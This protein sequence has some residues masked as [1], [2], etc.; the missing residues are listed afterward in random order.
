MRKIISTDCI[1]CNSRTNQKVLFCKPVT[2]IDEDSDNDGEFA[3]K[4]LNE[5]M[6]IQCAGCNTITFLER[7]TFIE[8]NEPG[9]DPMTVDMNYP[10]DY[11]GYNFLQ[12]DDLEYLPRILRNLYYEV[13]AAF[14]NDSEVLS[15]M[16]LR[17]LVEAI[18][19]QQNADGRNLQNK[20]IALKQKGLL[21]EH[22]LPILDKL[23]LI[24]NVAA[25]QI[26]GL[27]LRQLS[28][29]LDIVNHVLKSIYILP[30]INKQIRIK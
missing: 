30:Q 24:G 10:E 9:T 2:I 28:Y 3:T 20:I 25:H 19:M 26:K 23:R 17:T 14:K 7:I 16:G 21:S 27:P 12:E 11:P 22:E 8:P 13:I 5:Y 1:P 6:V 4:T 15:G 29:A 18:C